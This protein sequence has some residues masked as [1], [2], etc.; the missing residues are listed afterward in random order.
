MRRVLRP[1]GVL[2][3][4]T[5]V[6]ARAGE[7]RTTRP[8]YGHAEPGAAAGA[9]AFFER[10]YSRATLEERLLGA[11]WAEE[12]REYVRERR[13]VHARFFAARP[14]SFLVGGLLPLVC[15]RN[16]APV[17]DPADLPEGAHGVAYL[18]LRRPF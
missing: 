9:G 4:T 3:L 2:H 6:A 8:V 17:A 10:R 7:V 16:F 11:G 14:L 18:R 13:P 5:N 12:A 1:G 15:L